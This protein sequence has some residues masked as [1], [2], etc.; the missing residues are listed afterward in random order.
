[1][2]G[3]HW[4]YINYRIEEI[5]NELDPKAKLKEERE[6]GRILRDVAELLHSAEWWK[7][8]DTSEESFI[9]EWKKFKEKWLKKKQEDEK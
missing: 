8:G 3:G 4:D 1:M 6:F 2:S 5:A 9:E 7:S